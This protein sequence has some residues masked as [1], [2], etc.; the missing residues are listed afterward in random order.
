MT[1]LSLFTGIGG[2]DI[3]FERAGG[4][5]VAMC[6]KDEF[7]RAILRKRWPGIPIF[8]DVR[9]LTGKKVMEAICDG[10]KDKKRCIDIIYGGFP[11]QPFSCAGRRRSKS[12]ERYLWPE[13][14]RLVGEIKPVWCVFENVPGIL[15]LAADDVCQDLERQ[16]YAVGIFMHEAAAVGA[17]HRRMRAFFVAH[18]ESGRPQPRPDERGRHEKKDR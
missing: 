7:C 8:S 10:K 16:G 5:I 15:T 4:Q 6:E 9:E 18:A 3:A 11:C 1:G 14:A 17:P 2:L 13:C 12:D